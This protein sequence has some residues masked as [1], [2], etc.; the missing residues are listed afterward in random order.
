MIQN[1]SKEE[2]EKMSTGGSVWPGY[3]HQQEEKPNVINVVATGS[4]WEIRK[5]HS[6]LKV[7][8]TP[9]KDMGGES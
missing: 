8:L 4:D 2:I 9:P 6:T 3:F 7:K 5:K 1:F